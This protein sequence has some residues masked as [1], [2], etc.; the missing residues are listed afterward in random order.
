MLR[1][2]KVFRPSSLTTALL[3]LV[4]LALVAGACRKPQAGLH[5]TVSGGLVVGRD[6]DRLSVEVARASDSSSLAIET[7]EGAGLHGLPMTFNF[8]S[9]PGTPAGTE[10]R[11]S[12]RAFW[13]GEPVS[14]AEGRATLAGG[15]GASL[16]LLL[17]AR[18][19][20]DG[21][22]DA[23]FDGGEPDGGEPDGGPDGGDAGQDAGWD[24][25]IDGGP[26]AGIDAGTD[27]GTP[28]SLGWPCS[29][30]SQCNS[31]ICADG[32]CC[33][34]ACTGSCNA[35]NLSGSA[36]TCSLTPALSPGNPSCAPYLCSGTAGACPTQCLA[37]SECAATH[38]CRTTGQKTCIPRK[39]N[40]QGCGASRE[41][42]STFC[43]EGFCCDSSCGSNCDACNF[44]GSEGT[45][46]NQPSSFSTPTCLPYRCSGTSAACGTT[47]TSDANCGS[48]AYCLAPNCLPTKNNGT[49]CTQARECTSGNCVDGTCCNSTCANPCDAC[50]RAGNLGSCV[51][52][53]QTAP[54]S[55]SC[56]PYSCSGTSAFCATSC[57]AGGGCAS[58]IP[59]SSTGVCMTKLATFGDDFNDNLV[60]GR[61]RLVQS[62]GAVVR[63]QNAE[64]QLF[65]AF[66]SGSYAGVTS[67]APYDALASS[68]TVE[69]PSAGNQSLPTLQ[70]VFAVKHSA[71]DR[72]AITVEGNTLVADAVVDGGRTQLASVA[73]VPSLMRFLRIRESGG[74]TYFEYSADGGS[75]L[76][77]ASGAN[78]IPLGEVYPE[79]GAA[80]S[81]P[82]AS[83]T[84]VI[85][86]NFNN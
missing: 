21:G 51:S 75:Y 30:G 9:G 38:Y 32:V 64:L 70:V 4:A 46:T 57:T 16:E 55:P 26:D 3:P 71:L 7:A 22:E 1:P 28:G 58:G 42:L 62:G 83:G 63:E 56:A 66:T 54:G 20:P 29:A 24:G 13:G 49:S 59:C 17:P 60:S 45:C 76:P 53:P 44:A 12:A 35:C 25:G 33:S 77:L 14:L 8:V 6:F 36:G 86:D 85:F 47:C 43:V 67:Q 79:L 81:A 68:A 23:G 34:T 78:P 5:V 80:T 2:P 10:V 82:E 18:V 40:G 48:G 50:N 37:D 15:D 69:L 84:T 61:W 73:Y 74:T 72:V 65:T 19:V 11:V 41:C 39:A 31:N 27:A 52:V